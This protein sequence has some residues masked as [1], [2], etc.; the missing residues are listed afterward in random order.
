MKALQNLE[1]NERTHI[2]LCC[3]GHIIYQKIYRYI[4]YVCSSILLCFSCTVVNKIEVPSLTELI[5]VVD[6]QQQQKSVMYIAYWIVI[7]VKDKNRAR[8]VVMDNVPKKV[9][10]V[11]P[12]V[13]DGGVRA[14]PKELMASAKVIWCYMFGILEELKK[15]SSL[16]KWEV[17]DK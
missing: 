14:F 11:K 17:E 13:P 12:E 8:K 7:K 16:T 1:Q 10:W 6:T 9:F 5:V 2:D 15:N 3:C 4:K